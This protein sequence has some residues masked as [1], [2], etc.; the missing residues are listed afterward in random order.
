MGTKTNL[1][2]NNEYEYFFGRDGFGDIYNN[3]PSLDL[4]Q[5]EHAVLAL[6]KYIEK[7]CN[8][9]WFWN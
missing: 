1:I 9:G 6:Q 5:K 4:V 7:V 8:Y 2:N 3:K